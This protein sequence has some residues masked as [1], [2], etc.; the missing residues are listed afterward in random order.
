MTQLYP[1]DHISAHARIR[2]RLWY[3]VHWVG[4]PSHTWEPRGNVQ[5]CCKLA[6]YEDS[7]RT[8]LVRRIP[9]SLSTKAGRQWPPMRQLMSL[10]RVEVV[11]CVRATR[12]AGLGLFAGQALRHH[13]VVARFPHGM[14]SLAQW[15]RYCQRHRIPAHHAIQNHRCEDEMFYDVTY[16]KQRRPLWVYINHSKRRPNVKLVLAGGCVEFRT[17]GRV[18]KGTQLRWRYNSVA[19]EVWGARYTALFEHPP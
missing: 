16:S 9:K 15:T 18:R 8:Y 13:T 6:H 3:K 7:G 19:P 1:V 14:C 10:R 5:R 4:Y 12:S 17:V 2:G 11:V